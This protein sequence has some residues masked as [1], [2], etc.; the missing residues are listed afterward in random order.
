MIPAGVPCATI[1]SAVDAGAGSHVHD[2]VR[3]EDRF[4]IVLHHEHGVSEITQARFGFDEACV[5]ARVKADRR[6]VEHVQ[7]ADE[8]RADLRREANALPFT[9]RQ[10]LRASIERQIVEPHVDRKLRRAST[11]LSSG[12]GDGALA[13]GE[14]VLARV[15]K[16]A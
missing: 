10:S 16:T 6:L 15:K 14:A 1:S 2:V 13:R 4:A 9:R 12:S 3:R 5:V 11:A 8:R 7:N